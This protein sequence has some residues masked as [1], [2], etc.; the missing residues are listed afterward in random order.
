MA[1]LSASSGTGRALTGAPAAVSGAAQ[2][3]GRYQAVLASRRDAASV[4]AASA[5]LPPRSRRCA[6]RRGGAVTAARR[7]VVLSVASPPEAPKAAPRPPLVQKARELTAVTYLYDGACRHAPPRGSAAPPPGG[8][9]AAVGALAPTSLQPAA[10][11]R[12]LPGPLTP[13]AP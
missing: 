5:A 10:A 1:A 6:A 9:A 12:S 11:L 4:R 3:S 2:R 7:D 8:P 13:P